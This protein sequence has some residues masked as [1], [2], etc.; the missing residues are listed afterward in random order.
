MTLP[1]H[2]AIYVR[3]THGD[4]VGH[5]RQ[6]EECRAMAAERGWTVDQV[7]TDDPDRGAF[8]SHQSRVG[9]DALLDAIQ[10]GAVDG[11]VAWE[12][13]R[14]YRRREDLYVLAY[15]VKKAGIPVEFRYG[16]EDILRD[17]MQR[18][19]EQFLSM[20]RALGRVDRESRAALAR[21]AGRLCKEGEG[22]PTAPR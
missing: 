7:F 9:F 15:M 19:H 8:R 5:A 17:A 10:D 11:V 18:Q 1:L 14:L 6:E 2:A 22:K 16:L 12:V 4:L 13:D 20:Q 3:A 21:A